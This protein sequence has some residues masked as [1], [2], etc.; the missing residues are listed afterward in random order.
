MEY[1]EIEELLNRYLEGESSLEEEALLKDF[2]S[3]PGMDAKYREY[4]EMFRYYAAARQ[5]AVPPF[6]TEK[7]LNL[8]MEKEWKKETQTRFSRVYAWVGS[9][10]AVLV[11]SFGLFQYLDKPKPIVQD[12]F[13][14]SRLA[15][16]E[17][18]R[19]LLKVSKAMNRNTA[20]LKY[21]SKVDESFTQMKKISKIDEV[22]NSVKNQ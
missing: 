19:A 6:E 22:V 5:E 16:I 7:E 12:T 1:Q 18:K 2:F 21:L 20:S 9:A 15:Y 11:L 10:A 8:L 13:T 3:Q 17:T 14:D 4:Q